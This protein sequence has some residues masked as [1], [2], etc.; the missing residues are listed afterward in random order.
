M[1]VTSFLDTTVV[2]PSA[3]GPGVFH[4][5]PPRDDF[6][7]DLKIAPV[8]S[9][10]PSG[11]FQAALP[12]GGFQLAMEGPQKWMVYF[13]QNPIYKWMISRG[14]PMTQETSIYNM[15]IT[16]SLQHLQSPSSDVLV[17]S[18]SGN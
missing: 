5:R 14:T 15:Y 7:D 17:G 13:M 6:W 16:R 2:N 3:T 4:R 1:N 11:E 12:Y 18:F 9:L 8:D 10:V